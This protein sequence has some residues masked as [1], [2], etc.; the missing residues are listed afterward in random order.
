MGMQRR[1]QKFTYC[2]RCGVKIPKDLGFLNKD[3][4]FV[5]TCVAC[6]VKLIFGCLVLLAHVAPL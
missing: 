3:G 4:V 6:L 2:L 5:P 1:R